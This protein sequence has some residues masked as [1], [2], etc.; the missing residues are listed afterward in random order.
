MIPIRDTTVTRTYPVMNQCII[1]AN[2]LVFLVELAQGNALNRFIYIYGLV[3][4]RFTVPGIAAYFTTGQNLFSLLSFMFVHG[5]FWHILGNMWFLYIF[6]DNVE[7]RLGPLRYLGFYLLCGLMSG[8][9]HIATNFTSD[10]PTVG[11]SGAIAGVMG[12][13][14]ILYPH[15]RVLTLIP[16]II[17]PWFV[18]IPAFFF[19][20][21]WFLLQVFSATGSAG[22]GG[23]AWWAHIGGF[24]VGM[25]LLKLFGRMPELGISDALRQRMVKKKSH[26]LQLIRPSAPGDDA[27][28]HATIAVT[29][30]EALAGS[31]KLVSIPWGMQKR[32][33]NVVI[34][35]G[36]TSG[37]VL[38][39]RGL[40]K[41]GAG[42]SHGD[43]MLEVIITELR[44]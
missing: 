41:R 1:G 40:G 34:P 10:I 24:L 9:F 44:V 28:L 21:L 5:G 38:R 6:G 37:T 42:G 25:G 7:D 18:E 8:L 27:H 4:A 13:Y 3:P 14:F 23:I 11:A 43:L 29:P 26:R 33:F 19:L 32:L 30:F 31:R 15:A 35:P 39:L 17:I 22:S 36:I 12:A 2:V 20:G 16:I